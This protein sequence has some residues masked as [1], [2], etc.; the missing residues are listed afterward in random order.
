MTD[1]SMGTAKLS[2]GGVFSQSIATIRAKLLFFV[3]T[4]LLIGIAELAWSRS[5]LNGSDPSAVS[6]GLAAIALV[7]LQ[8]LG[9]VGGILCTRAT[10]G[11]LGSDAGSE[12]APAVQAALPKLLPV[13]LTSVLYGLIVVLGTLALV[14]PG[15]LAMTILGACIPACILEDLSPIGALKRSRE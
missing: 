8:V 4:G 11:P 9:A 10:A 2:V 14:I 3:F 15:V 6:P 12:F 7:L 13:I 5:G 1:L